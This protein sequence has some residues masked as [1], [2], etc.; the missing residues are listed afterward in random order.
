MPHATKVVFIDKFSGFLKDTYFFDFGKYN[1]A[2][3]KRGYEKREELKVLVRDR[4][5]VSGIDLIH[6]YLDKYVLFVRQGL[7]QGH[8]IF[9]DHEFNILNQWKNLEKYRR[10]F[11]SISLS[12]F[13]LSTLTIFSNGLSIL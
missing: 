13:K 10:S 4:K 8:Y 3:E 1:V 6:S 12:P 5:L 7:D 9:M 2:D 11:D